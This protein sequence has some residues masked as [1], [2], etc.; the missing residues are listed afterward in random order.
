LVWR[1]FGCL[2]APLSSPFR[3]R[4][5]SA[6]APKRDLAGLWS[7]SSPY[8][9]RLLHTF[10]PGVGSMMM[11]ILRHRCPVVVGG[12]PC[13]CCA[14]LTADLFLLFARRLSHMFHLVLLSMLPPMVVTKT[15]L[16]VV[17]D[18]FPY[19]Y[20]LTMDFSLLVVVTLAHTA[21]HL[22][23]SLPKM[24]STAKRNDQSVVLSLAMQLHWC[25]NTLLV[26]I[27][28]Q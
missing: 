11:A 4:L 2:Q 16:A 5:T 6:T 15:Y 26:L 21:F 22:V 8:A 7:S 14:R 1:A 23:I 20:R 27:D 17:D 3:V 25:C 19:Y 13:C 18:L 9:L 24:A 28:E 12:F 10:H